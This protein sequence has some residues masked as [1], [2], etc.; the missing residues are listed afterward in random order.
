MS[1]DQARIL[2]QPIPRNVDKDCQGC[3]GHQVKQNPE[4]AITIKKGLLYDDI[5][6]Y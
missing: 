6:F 4:K 5:D 3:R 2:G 1:V